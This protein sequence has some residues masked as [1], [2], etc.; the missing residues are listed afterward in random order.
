[1]K[2]VPTSNIRGVMVDND[3][4]DPERMSIITLLQRSGYL[5]ESEHWFYDET[6]G[7]CPKVFFKVYAVHAQQ[8]GDIFSIKFWF[9]AEQE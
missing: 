4:G 1:M 8:R 7:I 6:F 3:E 9:I 2:Q 5:L